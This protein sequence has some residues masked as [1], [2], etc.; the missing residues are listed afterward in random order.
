MRNAKT[1]LVATLGPSSD[2]Y[3]IIKQ[4]VLEGMDLVRINM[5]HGT[6]KEHQQKIEIIEKLR[7][8]GYLTAIMLD[9]KGPKIRC[10]LFENDGVQF[11]KD[12]IIKI[13]I[14]I[15]LL[16]INLHLMMVFCVL[17]LLIKKRMFLFVNLLMI[18]F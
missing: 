8:E 6:H 3:E 12:D 18:I 16:V 7:Q 5:S 15:Y 11:Y 1:K 17:R 9:L 2:N 10:G 13:Y 14:M 4:L